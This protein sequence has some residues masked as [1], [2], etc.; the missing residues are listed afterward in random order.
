VADQVRDLLDTDAV[1]GEDRDE[2]V[3][4]LPPRPVLPI[5][6][7]LVMERNVRRMLP[8]ASSVPVRVQKTRS[9]SCHAP[10]ALSRWAACLVW[11]SNCQDLW[12]KIF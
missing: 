5:P 3:A 11:W 10:P 8:A 6:A 1:V 12:I 4:Q 2:R 7:A 9:L